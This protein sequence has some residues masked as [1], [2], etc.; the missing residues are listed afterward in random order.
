MKIITKYI[1]RHFFT[2]L[3]I[4]LPSIISL[5]LV[6]EVFQHID[7]IIE[8]HVGLS[9]VISYLILRIPQIVLQLW[10][11]IALLAGILT[12]I[13]LSKRNEILA[14]KS[15]GIGISSVL[16]PIIITTL[17]C[18]FFLMVIQALWAPK[19]ESIANHIWQVDIEK[20]KPKGIITGK[21]LFFHSK[22]TIWVT[23]IENP[24]A[25]V[26]KDVRIIRYDKHYHTKF[27]LFATRAFY[28]NKKWHFIRGIIQ[29]KKQNIWTST[30]FKDLDLE[31]Y[32]IPKDL[33]SITIPPKL[34][35]A[36]ELISYIKSLRHAGEHAFKE[37]TALW[38][39]IS[40]PLLG[41]FLLYLGVCIMLLL[42][43]SSLTLGLAISLAI[44]IL[45]WVFWN[46][47]IA[48]ASSGHLLPEAVPF[49]AMGI[50]W[51]AS[52]II[53]RNILF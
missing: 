42:E 50:L 51:L 38:T 19:A 6:I 10:P 3:V 31:L 47:L 29:Q 24:R 37:R 33:A 53:K 4:I 44:G 41:V 18:S 49:L 20:K 48:F 8:A 25:T 13:V 36:M 2:L 35:N 15:C 26:L 5:Y 40:Y 12:I 34:M 11:I 17:I 43:R 14:I 27:F 23:F 28:V 22:N 39:S 1:I 16:K 52:S 32:V 21:L 9:I 46:F 45:Y 30:N 7:D